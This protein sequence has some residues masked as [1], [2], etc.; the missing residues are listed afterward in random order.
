MSAAEKEFLAQCVVGLIALLFAVL[1][2]SE[3]SASNQSIPQYEDD[4]DILK[5]DTGRAYETNFGTHAP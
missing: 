1:I 3:I 2:F 5:R 4:S